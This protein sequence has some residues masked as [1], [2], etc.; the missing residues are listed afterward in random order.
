[1][2]VQNNTLPEAASLVAD[3]SALFDD[4]KGGYLKDGVEI[5]AKMI[6]SDRSK[7]RNSDPLVS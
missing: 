1:M 7:G 2:I 6:V 5:L 3:S 4:G